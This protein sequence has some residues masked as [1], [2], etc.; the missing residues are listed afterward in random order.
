[1]EGEEFKRREQLQR[2]PAMP[3]GLY[4]STMALPDHEECVGADLL[5][6]LHDHRPE[7]LP[8]VCLPEENIDNRWH[9]FEEEHVADHAAFLEALEPLP[10]E[11]LYVLTRPIALSDDPDDLLPERSLVMLGYDRHGHCILFPAR[12]EQLSISFPER[13]YRFEN[14]EILDSLELVNF[15]VPLPPEDRSIH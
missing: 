3:C 11:G 5:L 12:Y 13:G 1:M 4:R 6:M 9:F 10:D 14:P 2:V 15:E 8:S 7:E